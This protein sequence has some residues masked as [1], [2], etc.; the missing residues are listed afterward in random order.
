[1]PEQQASAFCPAPPNEEETQR[2]AEVFKMFG[3]PTRVRILTALLQQERCVF[4]LS[5]L[6]DL[7]QSAV[8]HQLRLLRSAHLVKNRREGKLIYYSLDDDHVSTI[9]AK[10]L[11]HIRHRED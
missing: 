8:S 9:L 6:L 7:S 3:D 11:E 4:E 2:V 5:D 10:G 1:M